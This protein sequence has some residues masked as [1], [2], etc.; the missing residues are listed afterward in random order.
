[1]TK[2]TAMLAAALAVLGGAAC[3]GGGYYA[4]EVAYV[5][6][7]EY[8]YVVPM[9]QVVL[10]SRE[11][12]VDDGW[13]VFR[14]ERSGPSRILWA[15]R[16]PDQVVRIYATPRGDRVALRGVREVRED[17]GRHQGWVRRGDAHDVLA[18]IGGRLRRGEQG[19]GRGRGSR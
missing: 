17:D 6:P 3:A 16:G 5:S 14:V 11:V 13:T 12:R 9:D 19:R 2:H 1:M 18:A 8:A 10:V 4:G 7:A 15:R